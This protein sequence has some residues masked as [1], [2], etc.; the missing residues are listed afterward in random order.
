M[1][2][3][4]SDVKFRVW[5]LGFGVEC[6]ALR[7]LSPHPYGVRPNYPALSVTSRLL[8]TAKHHLEGDSGAPFTERVNRRLS[9][10]VGR[11]F[12]DRVRHP[13]VKSEESGDWERPAVDGGSVEGGGR[14]AGFRQMERCC[15]SAL[16]TGVERELATKIRRMWEKWPRVRTT[17]AQE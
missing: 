4:R 11:R 15:G 14:G 1:H 13:V 17:M 6:W 8:L 2:T 10:D 12:V 5:G 3:S 7:I 9:V 16:G